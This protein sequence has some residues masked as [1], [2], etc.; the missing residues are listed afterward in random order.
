MSKRNVLLVVAALLIAAGCASAQSFK[1]KVP[2]QF[3]ID[4][5]V[6]P[7]G[8]YWIESSHDSGLLT[9]EGLDRQTPPKTFLQANPVE[10][11]GLQYEAKLIFHC[12]GGSCFLSQ[13]WTGNN[14]G[15]QLGESRQERQLAKQGL[16]PR[17]PALAALRSVQ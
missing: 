4:K 7:A 2:F 10:S 11:L 6:M 8:D 13:V 17:V 3:T 9:I 14:V 12:Y 16:A 5:M 15:R 1:F